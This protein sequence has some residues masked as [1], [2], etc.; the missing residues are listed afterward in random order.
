M[1]H[2]PRLRRLT[3]EDLEVH[4]ARILRWLWDFSEGTERSFRAATEAFNKAIQ[5]AWC[6]TPDTLDGILLAE[7]QEREGERVFL[8]G[9][10]AIDCTE[11]WD[12]ITAALGLEARNWKAGK[13]E[14]KTRPGVS[15]K[16]R[17]QGWKTNHIVLTKEV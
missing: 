5:Y 13:M 14:I 8:V 7:V 3:R 9:A 12:V 15:K 6:L 1:S 17:G 10:A 11:S 16:I 2:G 4:Y